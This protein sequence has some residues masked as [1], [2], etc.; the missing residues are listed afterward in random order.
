MSLSDACRSYSASRMAVLAASSLSSLSWRPALLV[1]ARQALQHL[2]QFLLERGD[3]GLDVAAHGL[4]QRVEDLRLDHL[5]FV[6]RR[7]GEARRRA[8]QGDVL[9]LRLLAQRLQGFLVAGTEL[10]V[11]GAPPRLV[12]VALEARRQHVAQLVERRDH[13][14]GQGFRAAM[15]ELQSLGAIGSVE[16]VDIGPIRRRRRL[17]GFGPEVGPHRRGLARGRRPEHEHVE[18]VALDVDAELNGLQ[19]P[20]LADQP[21]DGQQLVGGLEPQRC[22]IDHAAQFGGLQRLGPGGDGG[23]FPAFGADRRAVRDA[24]L[25]RALEKHAISHLVADRLRER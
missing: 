2:A 16:I 8:Q 14:L 6:H 1:G 23:D 11:D 18:V 4:G 21:R 13:A 15:R 22:R 24:G 3:L 17:C 12:V 7:H 5:A 9:A 19:R 10:L 25:L 20:L